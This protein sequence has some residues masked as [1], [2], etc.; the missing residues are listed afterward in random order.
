MAAAVPELALR[1]E[2]TAA[3]TY[4]FV[5]KGDGFRSWALCTVNDVS[6]ELVI[7]SDWG[8]WAYRW[9][10]SPKTLGAVNLTA[11][12]GDRGSVDYIARKLCRD[13]H[14][15]SPEGTA[16]E[17]C[18][19]L[20]AR[21]LKDGREQLEGRLEEDDRPW[22]RYCDSHDENGLPL[23]SYEGDA[24]WKNGS[25]YGNNRLP[26][27]TK[28]KARSIWDDIH[29]LAGELGDGPGTEHVFWERLQHLDGFYDYVTTEPYEY[30]CTEQTLEDRILRETIL[31]ALIEACAATTRQ[32][33]FERWMTNAPQP[34]ELDIESAHDEAP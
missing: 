27:L 33:R 6:G 22:D 10:A 16:R 25:P 26:Y 13:S 7:T 12:L 31:P 9:H 3:T 19:L 2:M 1:S 15:F 34:P 21:R 24:S 14:R 11:F 32:R 29:D 23:L 4:S 18:K 28:T 17:L 30:V 20:V 5:T 8:S